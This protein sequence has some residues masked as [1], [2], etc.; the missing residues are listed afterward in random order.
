MKRLMQLVVLSLAMLA[1]TA[2]FADYKGR[3]LTVELKKDLKA[4]VEKTNAWQTRVGGKAGEKM[5]PFRAA[6]VRPLRIGG[7]TLHTGWII[8]GKI[9][10]TSGRT[11]ITG[12]AQPR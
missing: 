4:R 5:R 7:V 3:A 9:S 12:R 11:Y 1:S 6:S 10:T 8:Q 2:A